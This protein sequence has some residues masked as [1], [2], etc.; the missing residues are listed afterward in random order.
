MSIILPTSPVIAERK[1]PKILVIYSMPKVGK[2]TLLSQLEDCL[3]V[4]VEDGSDFVSGLKIKA[5]NPNEFLAICN[6]I[7]NQKRPYKIGALDTLTKFE[8][9]MEAEGTEDYKRTAIG[10]NFS[11][12]SVL[13][14]PHGGGYY[15]L[16][17]AFQ[18]YLHKFYSCFSRV[19][20]TAHVKDKLITSGDRTEDTKPMEDKKM[21]VKTDTVVNSTDIDLTG[22]IRNIA[23]AN[24]DAIGYLF[25]DSKGELWI[26]FQNNGSVNC[27]ARPEHLRGQ[28]FKF[29]WKR[30]Y[31]D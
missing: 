1:S 8:E 7:I 14:L 22:K 4:D 15:Y 19:V 30:I 28:I 26:S 29:D 21:A 16:R 20:L 17:Q 27:G 11:G 6:E 23:C 25:R 5:R 18:R 2:T 3:T 24:A 31:V 10:K 13:E 12:N 9:W